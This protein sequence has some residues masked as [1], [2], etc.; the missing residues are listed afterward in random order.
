MTKERIFQIIRDN[1]RE[2]LPDISLD[3]VTIDKSLKTLGANSIDRMDILIMTMEALGVKMPLLE[4][5][6][7]SNIQ[8]MVEVLYE[9][10][11][12]KAAK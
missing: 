6:R 5:A 3:D 12:D 2:I 9:V 4:F 7:T 8:D 10:S 1:I 11:T